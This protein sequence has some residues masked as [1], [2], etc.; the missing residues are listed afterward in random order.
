MKAD[1][2][3]SRML[4]FEM[5]FQL[6]ILSSCVDCEKTISINVSLVILKKLLINTNK[7]FTVTLSSVHSSQI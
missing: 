1:R 3:T 4:E 5:I 2:P 7:L 6:F